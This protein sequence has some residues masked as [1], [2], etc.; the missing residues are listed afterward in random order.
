MCSI[1]QPSHPPCQPIVRR[2]GPFSRPGLGL[3]G[4]HGF[5][6]RTR[7]PGR[8]TISITSQKRPRR[9]QAVPSYGG[10]VLAAASSS[11]P[12]TF[13]TMSC[14]CESLLHLT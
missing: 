1:V 3:H 14:S 11:F 2:P 7:A 6:T 4:M 12:W 13:W 8:P 5:C 10:D 9:L